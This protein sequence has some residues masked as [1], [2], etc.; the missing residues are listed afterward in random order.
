IARVTAAATALGALYP[1]VN[2]GTSGGAGGAGRAGARDGSAY[3]RAFER[4][5]RSARS[6]LRGPD[7]SPARNA[8]EQC[9]RDLFV[10]LEN[11]GNQRIGIDIS[12]EDAHRE[13][14]RLEREL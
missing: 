2:L 5:V 13:L 9:I 3:Q 11:L 1:T 10:E 8:Q 14:D 7:G 4:A 6:N 12:D